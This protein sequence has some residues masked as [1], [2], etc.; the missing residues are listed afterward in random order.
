M[1]RNAVFESG[2]QKAELFPGSFLCK[3]KNLKHLL[4]DIVLVDTDRASADLKAVQG[5]IIGLCPDTARIGVYFIPVL[6]HR[7]GERMV[8]RHKPVFLIGPLQQREFH[9][10]QE[11]EIILPNQSEL[12]TEMQ[13]KLT[14]NIPDNFIAVGGKQKQIPLLAVHGFDQRILLFLSHKFGKRRLYG[15]VRLHLNP[16][17]SS[18]AVSP[19]HLDQFVDLLAAHVSL[20]FYV[21]SPD[22]PVSFCKSIPEHREL[23]VLYRPGNIH[24]LHTEPYIRLI[25]PE[26]VHRVDPCHSRNRKRNIHSQ[27]M[28]KKIL[29]KTFIDVN[30]VLDI[31]EG[32]LHVNL[33][34]LRLTIRAQILVPEAAGQL[35]I[36]VI[37]GAH[38]KLLEQ[39]RRLRQR[40][41]ASRMNTAGNQIISGSFGCA[42]SQ[43]RC[44]Q[45]QKALLMEKL[46]G[47]IGN[48]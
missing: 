28:L 15:P 48:L 32:K 2:Q 31:H 37:A 7:H 34:K 5:N 1:R 6:F 47:Q 16:G 26:P 9:N 19:G 14:Q 39:L 23:A 38:Q 36:P 25:R 33:C 41:K 44:F 20:A 24:Q 46:T 29:Q 4:L 43:H 30:D 45:L 27:R 35:N 13:T 21:D 17:K 12:V 3:P 18:G 22:G 42:F 11:V 8:H 10:P 40:V